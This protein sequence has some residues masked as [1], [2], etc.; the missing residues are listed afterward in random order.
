V[1]LPVRE[2]HG[3]IG[4]YRRRR[5]QQQQ[6]QQQQQRSSSS[7][8]GETYFPIFIHLYVMMMIRKVYYSH[9][10]RLCLI[11]SL[12]FDDESRNLSDKSDVETLIGE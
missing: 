2:F 8:I 6:Q 7:S 11:T 10:H 12:S 5:Q 3:L 9:I 1:C 4:H